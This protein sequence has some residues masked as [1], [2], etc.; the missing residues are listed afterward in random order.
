MLTKEYLIQQL[1]EYWLERQVEG[2]LAM[3]R[4]RAQQQAP[5]VLRPGV[6]AGALQAEVAQTQVAHILAAQQRGGAA[7]ERAAGVDREI[8][9]GQ[10]HQKN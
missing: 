8:E 10:F 6:G 4:C 7:A 1:R 2:H 3:P 5:I 9:S